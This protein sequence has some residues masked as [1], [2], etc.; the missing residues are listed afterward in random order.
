MKEGIKG[1]LARKFRRQPPL[2]L[3]LYKGE[4]LRQH[5]LKDSLIKDNFWS[6]NEPFS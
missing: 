6:V 1:R 4:K 5:P 2:N 3:P